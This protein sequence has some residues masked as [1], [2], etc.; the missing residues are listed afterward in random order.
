MV[1]VMNT[2][3]RRLNEVALNNQ[4]VCNYQVYHSGNK[5]EISHNQERIFTRQALPLSLDVG[6]PKQQYRFGLS[7]N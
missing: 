2:K 5:I 7:R 4:S 3:A 6:F 1:A